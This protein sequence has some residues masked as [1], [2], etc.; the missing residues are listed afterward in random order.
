MIEKVV[1]V[2]WTEPETSPLAGRHFHQFHV[3]HRT[4]G[5]H[6]CYT[7]NTNDKLPGTVTRFIENSTNRAVEREA[8]WLPACGIATTYT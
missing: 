6:R 3:H 1:E 5:E 7:Y 8:F 2:E 4:Y